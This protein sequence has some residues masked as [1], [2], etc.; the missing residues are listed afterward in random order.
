MPELAHRRWIELESEPALLLV[1]PL[2]S[3]EQHG[4]HLPLG[5]DSIV[6]EALAAALV[7][8]RSDLVLGPT[9]PVGA[10]GEHRGFPGLLSLGT[11]VL[12]EVLTEL[13]RSARSWARGVVFVSGHGG[14]AEALG[15][16]LELGA[17]EGDR[18]C[19]VTAS[20]PGADPHAG[21]AETSLLLALAPEL[22]RQDVAVSGETRALAEIID[23]LR[24]GGIAPLSPSGVL[25]D[26]S[27]ASAQE[28]AERLT[29]MTAAG[30]RTIEECFGA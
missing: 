26:P 22:V 15:R 2:G 8:A 1:I 23:E 19:V 18:C 12:T 4:P 5:T 27:D 10:S 20:S 29:M 17:A 24:V 14:N 7:A 16:A 21:R 13:L 6:A 9:I 3:T 25:G 28:G 11:E 30:L